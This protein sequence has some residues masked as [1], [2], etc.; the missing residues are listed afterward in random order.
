MCGRYTLSTPLPV[1]E[2]R[3]Q[4]Q[5]GDLPYQPRYNIAPTLEVLTVTQ[6][7]PRRGQLMRWGL[8]PSWAKDTKIGAKMINARAEG[9]TESPAFRTALT[10]RRCLVLA[11]GFYEWRKEGNVRVP[12]LYVLKSREPFAFAGLWAVWKDPSGKW[13]RSCAI[14]TT[15]ANELVAKVH[16]R[17]SVILSEEAE[18]IWL[19]PASQDP[20]VLL[21]VLTPFPGGSMDGYEVSP[22]VNS[23]KNEGQEL[24][25]PVRRLLPL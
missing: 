2:E 24:A 8:V 14:V 1:L 25:A 22:L 21:G 16:N 11:D 5:A 20:R 23:V 15:D 9:L 18:R 10:K 6:N 13:L 3:F 19:D 17:M 7:S 4:F 12:L